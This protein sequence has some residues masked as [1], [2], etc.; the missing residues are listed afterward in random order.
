[1]NL[2]IRKT[3][4]AKLKKEKARLNVMPLSLTYKVI[5][6]GFMCSKNTDNQD[7]LAVSLHLEDYLRALYNNFTSEDTEEEK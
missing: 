6:D 3:V 1:M 2:E 7:Q 4:F 5:Y